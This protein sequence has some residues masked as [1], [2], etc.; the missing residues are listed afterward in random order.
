MALNDDIFYQPIPKFNTDR[1]LSECVITIS[2]I[3]QPERDNIARLCEAIGARVQKSLSSKATGQFLPNTHLICREPLGPK[4]EA[5]KNWKIPI[6]YPEWAIDCCVTGVRVEEDK[7]SVENGHNALATQL[8]EIL[9]GIR[10]NSYED[11]D[12]E[13]SNATRTRN[14]ASITQQQQQMQQSS[15]NLNDS[16]FTANKNE[17]KKPRLEE[18]DYYRGIHKISLQ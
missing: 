4:Y 9:D 11:D 7:F 14:E 5:A 1:P 18:D 13:D 12:D 3:D 15:N 10:T 17:S 8:I 6:V 2:G 16:S